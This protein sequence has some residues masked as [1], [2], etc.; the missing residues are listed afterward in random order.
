MSVTIDGKSV[1]GLADS[2]TAYRKA[3]NGFSHTLPTNNELCVLFCPASDP[4]PAGTMPP[5]PGAYADGVYIMLAPLSVGVHQINFT[6]PP[7]P[8]ARSDL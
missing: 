2:S 8:A 1:Q 6:A 3:A 7:N 4:F 5:A